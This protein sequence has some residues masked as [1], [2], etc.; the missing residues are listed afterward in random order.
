MVTF[1]SSSNHHPRWQHDGPPNRG[2]VRPAVGSHPCGCSH[3]AT[4]GLGGV[5]GCSPGC[6]RT[7]G[8][9]LLHQAINR[10]TIVPGP[11]YGVSWLALGHRL[12]NTLCQFSF[13]GL[14][15]VRARPRYKVFAANTAFRFLTRQKITQ[16]WQ[17]PM[18]RWNICLM[19]KI[20]MKLINMFGLL[21]FVDVN[22]ILI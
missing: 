21:Y 22:W 9:D 15:L 2:L 3:V 12:I 8:G 14:M 1:V 10:Y 19:C 20:I 13:T 11:Q 17:K 7:P 6:A 5:V 18:W 4:L 16:K